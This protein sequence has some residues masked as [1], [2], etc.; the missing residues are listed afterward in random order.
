M[1]R[2]EKINRVVGTVIAI[3]V[4]VGG[5][6][7]VKVDDDALT[8]WDK[9]SIWMQQQ[10]GT[11]WE[12]IKNT[13]EF[14]QLISSG[15]PE[16]AIYTHITKKGRT[17]LHPVTNN[18]IIRIV[19][20]SPTY[21]EWVLKKARYSYA[22]GSL[23]P[24]VVEKI[25]P[26]AVDGIAYADIYFGTFPQ[27]AYHETYTISKIT[28]QGEQATMQRQLNWQPFTSTKEDVHILVVSQDEMELLVQL[29]RKCG[30]IWACFDNL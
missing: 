5:V 24:D 7:T 6:L 14:R 11:S 17:E 19:I 10:Y 3:L 25:E 30:V 20:S 2:S 8:L 26:V 4:I 29:I 15:V 9:L 13:P 22:P 28:L 18:D 21:R 27:E 23:L 16:D 12:E 1:S